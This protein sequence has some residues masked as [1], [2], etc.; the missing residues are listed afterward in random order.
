MPK[1]SECNQ[2]KGF[3]EL[4]NGVCKSCLSKHEIEPE[5]DEL[6]SIMLSSTELLYGYELSYI[7]MVV[8]IDLVE[9]SSLRSFNPLLYA[10]SI[11]ISLLGTKGEY[12][13]KLGIGALN[14]I[15]QLKASALKLGANAVVG[16]RL[17]C[18]AYSDDM[19]EVVVYGTAVKAIKIGSPQK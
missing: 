17:E 6:D 7:D 13:G 19:V 4:K 18:T 11:K 1:C 10:R 12:S 14:A 16:V 9:L 5:Y 15:N 2:S 8:A 3:L